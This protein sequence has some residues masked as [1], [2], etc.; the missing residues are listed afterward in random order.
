M[1][2]LNHCIP[3]F[4]HFRSTAFHFSMNVATKAR[5]ENRGKET[6]CTS[7]HELS[8]TLTN[9]LKVCYLTFPR[10]ITVTKTGS[11]VCPAKTTTHAHRHNIDLGCCELSKMQLWGMTQP[12]TQTRRHVH[13]YTHIHP[14][15]IVNAGPDWMELRWIVHRGLMICSPLIQL[16][17]L[18]SRTSISHLKLD[19]VS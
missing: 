16:S 19:Y 13:T 2:F 15:V 1:L 6:D 9:T 3:D 7:P 4:I 17:S 14:W 12:Y 8:Q 11:S 18:F 10:E 5:W